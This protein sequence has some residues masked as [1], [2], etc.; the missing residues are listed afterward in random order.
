MP[1]LLIPL[2]FRRFSA[3]ESCIL[4]TTPQ[5]LPNN[6]Q[7]KTLSELIIYPVTTTI[8][9]IIFQTLLKYDPLLR[10]K[11]RAVIFSN[12]STLNIAKK[13]FSVSSYKEKHGWNIQAALLRIT[14]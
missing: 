10:M 1:F 7:K 12:A 3:R 8:K 11:P 2:T 13:Y 5:L 9:S 14:T 6:G 4:I